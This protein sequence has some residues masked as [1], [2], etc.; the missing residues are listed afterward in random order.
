MIAGQPWAAR[1]RAGADARAVEGDADRLCEV[2]R[3]V[4]Q[5]HSTSRTK[6][7]GA[8]PRGSAAAR[9]GARRRVGHRAA[10]GKQLGADLGRHLGGQARGDVAGEQAQRRV[11]G[12]LG[13]TAVDAWRRKSSMAGEPRA[14]S[15]SGSDPR[16]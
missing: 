4:A 15:T 11:V 3:R 9:D 12:L 2:P 8:E 6:T 5:R 10:P 7:N 1:R 14:R 16:S 13:V